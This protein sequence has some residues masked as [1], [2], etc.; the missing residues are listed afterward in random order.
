MPAACKATAAA[1]A[2]CCAVQAEMMASSASILARRAAAPA[3]RASAA[4]VSS[5]IAWASAAKSASDQHDSATHSRSRHENAPCGTAR[6]SSLPQRVGTR[7]LAKK[8]W[9]AAPMKTRPHS[10]CDRS[11]SAPRPVLRLRITPASAAD[12]PSSEALHHAGP[13]V[14]DDEIAPLRHAARE[15]HARRLLEIDGDAV[16]RI[17]EEGEAAAAVVAVT[18]VLERRVLN[19]EAVGTFARFHVNGAGAEIGQHLADMGTRGVAAEF[20]NF[21][22]GERLRDRGH[23]RLPARRG[24]SAIAG[25]ACADFAAANGAPGA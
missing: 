6:G 11:M 15:R 25:S 24:G 12:V 17:V 16:F 22:P 7:P 13:H 2:P 4:S 1:S 9:S 21:E 18:I 8:S 5:P 19:A 3:K 23:G 14:L 20:E 10:Y